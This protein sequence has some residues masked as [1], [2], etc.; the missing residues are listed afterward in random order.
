MG[1]HS[2]KA[3]RYQPSKTFLYWFEDQG[4]GVNKIE[5]SVILE[6]HIQEIDLCYRVNVDDLIGNSERQV[7]KYYEHVLVDEARNSR[8]HECGRLELWSQCSIDFT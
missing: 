3:T 7:V 1:K 8:G 5:R 4:R 2:D 6:R